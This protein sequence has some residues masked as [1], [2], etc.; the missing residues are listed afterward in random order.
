MAGIGCAP[1]GSRPRK[2]MSTS[3]SR[4][5]SRI[6]PRRRY[7]S[8]C[9]RQSSSSRSSLRRVTSGSTT[10]TCALAAGASLRAQKQRHSVD[11]PGGTNRD[12]LI[13]QRALLGAQF[14]VGWR[15]AVVA[16]LLQRLEDEMLERLVGVRLQPLGLYGDDDHHLELV[17][18]GH[19]EPPASNLVP[20]LL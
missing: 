5:P 2:P 4:R 12:A 6:Q 11:E 13:E 1:T 9:A 8:S 16:A 17:L 20:Q 15:L 19:V 18:V 3:S 14:P 10:I 7:V